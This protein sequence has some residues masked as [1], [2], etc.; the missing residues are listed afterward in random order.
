M[1]S[2]NRFQ[3]ADFCFH[4][5]LATPRRVAPINVIFDIVAADVP[6]FLGMDVLNL[7][8]LGGDIFFHRLAHRKLITMPDG[9]ERY[10]DD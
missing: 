9:S 6:E 1:N 4:L 3:F 2:R 10:L 5:T 8:Q 7:E